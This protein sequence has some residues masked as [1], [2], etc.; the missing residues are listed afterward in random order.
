MLMKDP[1]DRFQ[2][3]EELVAVDPGPAHRRARRGARSSAAAATV[4][5]R[6]SV[7]RR[8]PSPIGG[9]SPPIVSQPTTPID[10]PLSIAAPR[11]VERR[12]PAAAGRRPL[13]RHARRA[14]APGPGS[15]FVL[16]VLGGG[17]GAFYYYKSR[18]F[19]PGSGD[20]GRLGGR[21]PP[22]RRPLRDTTAARTPAPTRDSTPSASAPG[23]DAAPPRR[24]RPPE[25]T[26]RTRQR[27]VAP[28]TGGRR[29]RRH[30]GRRPA[31]RLHGHDRREAGDASPSPG[32]PRARMRS[33][34]L[35]A[36]VQLLLRYDRGPAGGDHRDEPAAHAD[37]LARRCRGARA[38]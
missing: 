33:A 35:G 29:Q 31:A 4:G 34:C 6:T 28:T 37:R 9:M 36:A 25:P 21:P 3:C 18:G 13:A 14:R 27:R 11:R 38:A 26:P 2:S 1:A 7:G 12:G 30:P 15:G 32:C 10:S 23:A 19:A 24:P 8:S 22:T 16:A 17:G 5:G 20:D